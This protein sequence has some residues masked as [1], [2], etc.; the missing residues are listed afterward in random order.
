G[1]ADRGDGW[2]LRWLHPSSLNRRFTRYVSFC[3][4]CVRTLGRCDRRHAQDYLLADSILD[5]RPGR[6]IQD[7]QGCTFDVLSR[8]IEYDERLRTDTAN[9][10]EGWSKLSDQCSPNGLEDL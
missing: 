4:P 5:F 9:F 2:F 10:V 3:P 7:G 6:R 8:D 1:D